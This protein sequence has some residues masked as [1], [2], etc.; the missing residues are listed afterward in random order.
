MLL[1][2]S[3]EV[4]EQF[5][6]LVDQYYRSLSKAPEQGRATS[7]SEKAPA[8]DEVSQ[9]ARGRAAASWRPRRCV[10]GQF[11]GFRGGGPRRIPAR[12]A[13]ADSFDGG[14]N[15]CR[16]SY[17]QVRWEDGGQGW[18]TDY[19]DADINFSVRL[20][21]L[22]KTRISRQHGGEPNH[23]VVRADRRRAVPVPVH[24]DRGC[25]H[26]VVQRRGGRAPARLPAERRLPLVGRFL[27]HA[28]PGSRSSRSSAASC[29][30]SSIQS[31]T[32][33][34][35]IRSS[36]RCSS[37]SRFRRFR[38]S[39]TGAAAAAA[40]RSAATTAQQVD[41]AGIS[42]A[43][44]RL[45]VL[46]THNTDI[47]DAW[48][49]EAEDPRFFYQFSPNGYAVGINVRAL[50]VDALMTMGRSRRGF[51]HDG[52]C[53]FVTTGHD[54]SKSGAGMRTQLWNCSV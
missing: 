32:S 3:D 33:P 38:R 7:A 52:S 25:R 42:D 37:S 8:S 30:R 15:F 28:P 12:F 14:F 4:P 1:S 18:W 9:I 27:G 17:D 45:M 11:Q 53:R 6:K 51:A 44:G 49:R 46:M 31:S 2:G 13:T 39:S 21:E 16:L 54:A 22:T 43:N 36:G 35:S 47:S 20:S 40:P 50:R 26:G 48:E 34:R 41:S 19:P 10:H 24:R 29:R 5:R 23:L